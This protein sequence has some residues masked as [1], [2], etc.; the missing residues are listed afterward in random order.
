MQQNKLALDFNFA[1][2]NMCPVFFILTE[3]SQSDTCILGGP[4]RPALHLQRSSGNGYCCL[5]VGTVTEGTFWEGVVFRH[6]FHD[7]QIYPVTID[8][9]YLRHPSP[10]PM[11]KMLPRPSLL[12]ISSS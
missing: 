4:Q 6:Y 3:P 1:K 2:E 11:K 10:R 9:I 5:N 8:I 12:C 7:T